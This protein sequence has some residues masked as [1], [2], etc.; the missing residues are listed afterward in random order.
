MRHS[1]VKLTLDRYSH[2]ELHDLAEGIE[3]LPSIPTITP[4]EQIQVAPKVALSAANSGASQVSTWGR[5][6]ADTDKEHRLT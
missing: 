2:V 1:D 6:Q 3:Q 5:E 4:K